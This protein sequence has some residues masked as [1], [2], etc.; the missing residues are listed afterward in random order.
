MPPY[1]IYFL[2]RDGHVARPPKFVVADDDQQAS[3]LARQFI[4]GE[5]VLLDVYGNSVNGLHS[6]HK[7]RP[8]PAG[9]SPYWIK[10]KNRK[11]PA[12][13]RVMESVRSVG[14]RAMP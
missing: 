11:H 2:D 12:M 8:Y 1:R 13:N 6:K 7:D 3:E 5:A 14:R 9:R 4:D 10:I